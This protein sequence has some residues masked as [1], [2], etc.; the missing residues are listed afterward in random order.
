LI[1]RIGFMG[2]G[3]T[4]IGHMLAE[5]LGRPFLDSDVVLERR[6][7]RT[8][9]EIFATDGEPAFRQIEHDTIV[10]LLAGEE[11]VLAL[12]GGAVMRE[13]TRAALRGHTV[14]LLEVDF[15]EAIARIGQDE[16]RPMLHLPG[17]RELY[18]RRL[19][20]YQQCAT[21]R[22]NTDGRRADA[23]TMDLL[24]RLSVPSGRPGVHSVLVS[25]AG[26]TYRVHI[27]RGLVDDVESLLPPL[28]DAEQVF[29]A[30]QYGEE[31][32]AE[33]V[34]AAMMRQAQTVRSLP[35]GGNGPVGSWAA[36]GDLAGELAAAGAHRHD[37]L[38]G[39]GGET[40]CE[41]VGFTGAVYHRGMRVAFV[42]TT[43]AAQAD[44]AVGGKSAVGLPGASRAVGAIHQPVAVV[45]DVDVAA[46]PDHED[47]LDGL[48]EVAKHAL[49]GGAALRSLL[50][51]HLAGLRA[52][53]PVAVNEIVRGS[54]DFKAD[55]VSA[56]EREEGERLVLGYGHEFAAAIEQVH[57]DTAGVVA[58]GMTAAAHLAQF[59]GM[60][61]A[62]QAGEHAALL[63]GLGLPGHAA[64][65]VEQVT[66]AMHRGTRYQRGVRVVLLRGLGRP[67]VGVAASPVQIRQALQCLAG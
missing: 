17:V 66:A 37:L 24:Q 10:D 6:Q 32:V 38:I 2:A 12:G 57:G 59:L 50:A 41:T 43:L 34:S 44:S 47:W 1:V 42:A 39:V 61:P 49:V 28:P 54:V 52:G 46:D 19:P 18:Q 30:Y 16:F 31:S 67:V 8:I 5:R 29:V 23:I 25:P 45:C 65:D 9:K 20:I 55:V 21:L 4:T 15:D 40:L 14:V 3:K 53:D 22:V 26:G 13:D 51:A 58:L 27:G 33:R 62:D 60:L 7:A 36:A 11:V 56:D 63:A 64:L 48:A 35:V